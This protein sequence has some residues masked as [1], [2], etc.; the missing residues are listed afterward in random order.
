MDDRPQENLVAT[1]FHRECSVRRTARVLEMKQRSIYEDLSQLLNHIT[2]LVPSLE[3]EGNGPGQPPA[4]VL[5][6]ALGRLG[7]PAFTDL[8]LQVLA[9]R[10]LGNHQG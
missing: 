2:L 9:H 4:H 10:Q 7:D 5:E 8:V 6:E 3:R 1:E